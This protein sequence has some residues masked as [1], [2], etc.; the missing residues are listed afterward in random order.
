MLESTYLLAVD[1][2]VSEQKLGSNPDPISAC[3]LQLSVTSEKCASG[4]HLGWKGPAGL[5][6]F[7]RGEG[8][9]ATGQ[10]LEGHLHHKQNGVARER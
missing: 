3:A 7:F 6:S 5:A 10:L 8:L 1:V 9:F 4:G 2:L